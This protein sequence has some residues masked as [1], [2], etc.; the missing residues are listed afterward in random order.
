MIY[1]CDLSIEGDFITVGE[2]VPSYLISN[3]GLPY[4]RMSQTIPKSCIIFNTSPKMEMDK[5]YETDISFIK[6]VHSPLFSEATSGC[7]DSDEDYRGYILAGLIDPAWYKRDVMV[8]VVSIFIQSV[9][10][11]SPQPIYPQTRPLYSEPEPPY[12]Q[13]EPLH[14]LDPESVSVS[15]TGEVPSRVVASVRDYSASTT[16][17]YTSDRVWATGSAFLSSEDATDE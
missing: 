7:D 8:K 17:R 12:S 1:L 6:V 16:I 15:G 4:D 3:N 9:K 10:I 14:Q 11:L 2:S 13:P 5:V